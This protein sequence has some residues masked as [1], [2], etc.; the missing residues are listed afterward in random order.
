MNTLFKNE[1]VSVEYNETEDLLYGKWRKCQSAEDYM[2]AIREYKTIF[3][4]ILPHKILWNE[5]DFDFIIPSDLQDWTYTFLDKPAS[6]L[7]IDFQLAHIL[8]N[9]VLASLPIIEMFPEG[10]TYYQPRFFVHEKQALDWLVN[11][12]LAAS[13]VRLSVNKQEEN[14][15][16]QII[17]DINLDHLPEFLIE[18]QK[19]FKNR[20]FLTENRRKYELLS[21]REKEILKLVT[22]NCSSKEIADQL[23]LSIETVKT[24]R[25]NMLRKLQC[26]S[27]SELMSYAVFG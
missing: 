17:L 7:T 10:K 2:S 21:I 26:K 4:K 13:D 23:C 25:K 1:I 20:Y 8:P 27:I 15:R 5:A 16:A 3:E 9:E 6:D 11:Q 14:S 19:L 18:F 24:H 12:S 22:H